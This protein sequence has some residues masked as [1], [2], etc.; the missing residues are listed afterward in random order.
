MV[1]GA[2][3]GGFAKL[4]VTRLGAE[5]LSCGVGGWAVDIEGG[6]LG[7]GKKKEKYLASGVNVLCMIEQ[8]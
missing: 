6:V 1:I 7:L 5:I 2:V 3:P 4:G 8:R